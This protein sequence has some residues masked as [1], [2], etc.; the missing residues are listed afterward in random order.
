MCSARGVWLHVD[1]AYGGA[2][3]CLPEMAP[4]FAGLGACDSFCVNAHKALLCPF[5][6]AAL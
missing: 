4:L 5:D 3:A 6:L 2:Y 1:A